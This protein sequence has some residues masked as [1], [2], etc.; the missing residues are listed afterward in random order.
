MRQTTSKSKTIQL[1]S[2]RSTDR[3]HFHYATIACLFRVSM[4][5][6]QLCARFATFIVC[7]T[8]PLYAGTVTV[9]AAASLKES[10]DDLAKT[11]EQSTG[12]Q[13]VVAYAASSALARQIER[14]APADVFFS[15]DTDWMDYLADKKMIRSDSRVD[16]L[17]NS[18]VLVAPSATQMVLTIQPNFPL[19]QALGHGRLAIADPKSVPAGKYAKSALEV[20]GVW[21]SIEAKLAPA[22]N[23]RAAL[24]FVARGEAPLG[25]VYKTDAL[26]EKRVRIVDTFA[27]A[28]HPPIVYP[29]ALTA[30]TKSEY[31]AAFLHFLTS[32]RAQGL[33]KIWIYGQ[34]MWSDNH[35]I[36]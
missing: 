26:A 7:A 33:G 14:G 30:N 2:S 1:Y 22:E 19:S 35:A 8:S 36:G 13:V 5:F 28:T 4:K 23:V 3:H 27:P 20:L 31:A 29:V 21:G 12:H 16:L 24:S 11:F 15:A 34:I 25:V 9:F 10:I 6:H 17:G 32:A 18:I